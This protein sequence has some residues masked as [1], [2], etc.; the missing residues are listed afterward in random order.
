M[1]RTLPIVAALAAAIALQPHQVQAQQHDAF[2]GS[3][4]MTMETPRGS[5]T[6]TIVITEA[7]GG[8]AGTLETPRGTTD[9]A[10][11][12]I[13]DGVLSFDVTRQMRGNSMTQSFS[14]T[15]DGDV[16][17]GTMSGGRGGERPFSASRC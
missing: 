12:S 8:L 15:V 2:L 1:I 13:T 7:D 17:S 3:W 10:N 16:M 5:I 4:E 11:V 6:Q 14:A 9:L